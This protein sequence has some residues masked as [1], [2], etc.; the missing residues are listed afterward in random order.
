MPCYSPLKAY[1][2]V[3]KH[4][5]SGKPRLTFNSLKAIN[6]A[7]PLHLPCGQCIGCRL[8]RSEAWA[9]RCSH[10]AQMHQA[11]AFITLTYDDAYLPHDYSVDKRVFQL[12]MKRLRK[13]LSGKIRFFACGEY[14]S[15][16]LRPHYHALIFGYGFPDR[17][18]FKRSPTGDLFTSEHLTQSWGYGHCTLGDVTYESAGYTAQ[19]AMKKIGGDIA[20]NHYTR[21][22]PKGHLVQVQPEFGLASRRPGIGSTWF[23]KFKSD[24]FPS[25]F[26]VV[27]GRQVPVPQYYLLKLTEDHQKPI[28]RKRKLKS[29]NPK[30][31]ANRTKERLAVRQAV[32]EARLS[33]LKRTL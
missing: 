18:L 24:A 13:S 3:E 2:S 21:I 11:N 7:L 22:H 23:D 20:T 1:R 14:G 32:R 33:K 30:R 12:F 25:D 17:Q 27:D 9:V 10:E 5:A 31:K 6:S 15:E 29:A 19:Y 8:D 4:D 28:K 16:N 26:L